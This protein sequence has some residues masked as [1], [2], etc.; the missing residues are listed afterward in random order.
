MDDIGSGIAEAALN[1]F[2]LGKQRERDETLRGWQDYAASLERKLEEVQGTLA[3]TQVTV[4]EESFLRKRAQELL[5][6][7]CSER[8]ELE[9][10][11]A[12]R[13]Q[14][15]DAVVS[16]HDKYRGL[17]E[18]K[19]Q[20]LE[21]AL[22]ASSARAAGFEGILEMLKAE[23]AILDDPSRF[24]SLNIDAMQAEMERCWKEFEAT[25]KLVYRSKNP[26]LANF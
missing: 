2:R 21:A 12:D 17:V 9:K 10:S 26:A 24:D 13:E 3:S 18:G 7:A 23:I 1:G 5:R 15:L 8:D 16:A 4:A 22:R 20:G 19:L 14:R 11:L 25:G 6:N